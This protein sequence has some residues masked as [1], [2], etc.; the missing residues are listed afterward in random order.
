MAATNHILCP[1][2]QRINRVPNDRPARRAKCGA[3]REPLFA[4]RPTAVDEAGFERHLR[5][6]DIPV[7]VD[8]WAPWC[9]PC[10]S[11][12]PMFERAAAALEP[13]VRLLKLNVDEAQATAS[14]LGITGIPALLLFHKGRVVGRTAGA[15]S[16]EKIVAWTRAHV[17]TPMHAQGG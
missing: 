6:D 2:C 3:C 8:M 16:A 17:P 11:M 15:M 7:L 10:R 1:R 14:R 12:A 4:G 5:Q 9:G 13:D